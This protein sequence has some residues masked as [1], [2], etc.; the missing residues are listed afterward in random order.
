[1]GRLIS[2]LLDEPLDLA[3]LPGQEIDFAPGPF[4]NFEERK[5]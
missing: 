2:S 3:H 1:M 4:R 5:R